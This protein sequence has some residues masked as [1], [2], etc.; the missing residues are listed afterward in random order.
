MALDPQNLL[1]LTARLAGVGICIQTLEVLANAPELRD[2]RLLG[3]QRGPARFGF[4][5]RLPRMLNLFPGCRY[6]LALRAAV[7]A[8]VVFIPYG[9]TL[10][11]GMLGLL[12]A[13]Q[14]Y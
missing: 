3:W 2:D 14:L 11:A 5:S 7:S 10:A 8:L 13:L 1:G 12:L 4:W 6:T 9:G